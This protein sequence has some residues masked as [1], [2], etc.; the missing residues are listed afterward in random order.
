MADRCPI[1]NLYKSLNER[2]IEY[3]LLSN[4]EEFD[5]NG[6]I[7]LYVPIE[8]KDEF[9]KVMA[10]LGWYKRK[11]PAIQKYK[12]FY[13]YLDSDKVI[14]LDVKYKLY[15][16]DKDKQTFIYSKSYQNIYK[17]IKRTEFSAWRPSGPDALHLYLGHLFY[18]KKVIKDKHIER[19][20]EYLEKYHLEL[21]EREKKE[22]E[23]VLIILREKNGF[24][25]PTTSYIQRWFKYLKNENQHL[26]KRSFSYGYKVLVLGTDGTGKSSLIKNIRKEIPVKTKSIYLGTGEDGWELK[27]V[28]KMNK[29]FQGPILGRLLKTIIL[30]IEFC[31]RVI[32]GKVNAKYKL[33]LIDR[34]PGWAIISKNKLRNYIYK[35]IL[36]KPDLVIFLHGDPQI[37]F[38]RKK[39]RSVESISKDTLKFKSVAHRVCNNVLEINT[40]ELNERETTKVVID[41]IVKEKKFRYL[42]FEELRSIG[43]E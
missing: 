33:I 12:C 17:N 31:L 1:S 28:K 40:T 18:E 9:L 29:N 43:D 10:E 42:L 21:S 24:D 35:I 7:D 2:N 22:L 20:K 26:R 41:Y 25:E 4:F 34:F 6:D 36:P 39:E 19:L 27:Q 30:P 13:Y 5:P 38:E 11:E 16:M 3:F 23:H 15:F 32:R 14:Y 37:L 8:N